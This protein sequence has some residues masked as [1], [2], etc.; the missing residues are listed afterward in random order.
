MING[1]SIIAIIPARGGSKGLPRKNIKQLCG[2]PLIAWSIEVGLGSTYVDEV[3]V[4]TD[5]EE[6]ALVARQFG[7]STPFMRPPELASDTA[8]SFDVVKHAI[9]FYRVSMGREFD[10]VLLLEPTSPLRDKVDVNNALVQLLSN[11]SATAIVGICKTES[12]HPAFLVKKDAQGFLVGYENA[13]MKVLR[14][15]DIGEVLFFEG[16]VYI[17]QVDILMAKKTFYHERTIGYEVP[18][19][20]S[21]EIDDMD[22]FIVVEALMKFKEKKS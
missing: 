5:S 2:K 18:K 8:T 11:P 14:R 4:T 12:Q 9:D 1:K 6:I 17:S 16:S 10:Y 7:A 15:Q 20:K 19:W 3:M 21:F 13:E 22:D